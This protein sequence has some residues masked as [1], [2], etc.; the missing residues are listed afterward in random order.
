MMIRGSCHF[1]GNGKYPGYPI[2][3][4]NGVTVDCK[5]CV[6][7]ASAGRGVFEITVPI[8]DSETGNSGPARI[9]CR[10]GSG[11]HTVD[12]LEWRELDQQNTQSAAGLQQRV[13]AVLDFLAERR[14]CGNRNICPSQVVEIVDESSTG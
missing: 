7:D 9:R 2:L 14:I 4:K 6:F 8:I 5:Q 1:V 12:L 3:K 11:H 13:S 10:T